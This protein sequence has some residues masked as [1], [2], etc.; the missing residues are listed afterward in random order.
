VKHP[1]L[2]K[3]MSL[4]IKSPKQYFVQTTEIPELTDIEE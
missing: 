4:A 3:L 2:N 1:S